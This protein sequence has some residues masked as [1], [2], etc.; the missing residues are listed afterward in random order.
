MFQRVS[1]EPSLKL[2]LKEG[3]GIQRPG[4]NRTRGKVLGG[5]RVDPVRPVGA[6]GS[7]QA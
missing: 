6:I 1:S 5:S 4:G 2:D 3:L 7:S